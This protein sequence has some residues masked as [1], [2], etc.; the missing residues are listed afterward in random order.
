MTAMPVAASDI[1][2]KD[3]VQIPFFPENE[4]YR[5]TAKTTFTDQ[6][7]RLEFEPVSGQTHSLLRSR[8]AHESIVYRLH[9]RA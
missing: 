1:N 6:T 2:V 7:V 8:E 5:V 4:L 3:V 9:K